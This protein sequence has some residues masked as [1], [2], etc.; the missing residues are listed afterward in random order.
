MDL[1]FNHIE[2]SYVREQPSDDPSKPN[3]HASTLTE[4]I[5]ETYKA[6]SASPWGAKIGGFLGTV[7]KQVC[8]LR[9]GICDV[10][11]MMAVKGRIGLH[12]SFQG[13]CGGR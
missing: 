5:Q 6:F 12:S 11:L 4:D 1:A 10:E 13:A 8:D 3:Q 2:D 9:V 7:R